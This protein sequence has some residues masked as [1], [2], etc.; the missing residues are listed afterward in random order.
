MSTTDQHIIGTMGDL[1]A[2]VQGAAPKQ[3]GP[4]QVLLHVRHNLLNAQFPEIPF[5]K[6]ATLASVR[7]KVASMTGSQATTMDLYLEQMVLDYH[8]V[9]RSLNIEVVVITS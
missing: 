1:K 7:D 6:H 2:W 9:L 4:D 8:A 5:S 3:A